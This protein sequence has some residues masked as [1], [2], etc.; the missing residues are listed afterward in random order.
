MKINIVPREQGQV[1]TCIKITCQIPCVVITLFF[2]TQIA[3][4]LV[5]IVRIMDDPL[6]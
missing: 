4:M 6:Y 5:K 1:D 3:C 2:K